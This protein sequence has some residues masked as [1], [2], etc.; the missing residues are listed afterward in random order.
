MQLFY[1]DIQHAIKKHDWIINNS[2][3]LH[4]YRDLGLLESA[5]GHIQNDMYYPTFY[6]KLKHLIYSVNKFHPFVDGNKRSSLM[7]GAYFLELI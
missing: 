7:L 2:G 5:L 4:G 1:F 6:E 3:G